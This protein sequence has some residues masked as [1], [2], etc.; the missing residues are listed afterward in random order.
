MGDIVHDTVKLPD[1]VVGQPYEAALAYHGNATALSASAV[2]SGALPAGLSLVGALPFSKITGT[3]T[4]PAGDVPTVFTFTLSLTD[5]AG[6]V[7]SPTL[8]IT[9]HPDSF[10][11]V[12]WQGGEAQAT[13]AARSILGQG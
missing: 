7:T 2:V 6:A 11:D 13:R 1:A 8:T 9:V 4:A 10:S 5:T 3:P 12:K